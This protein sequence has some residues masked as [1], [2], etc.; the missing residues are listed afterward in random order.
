MERVSPDVRAVLEVIDEH[1]FD[2][3]FKFSSIRISKATRAAFQEQLRATPLLY[4]RVRRVEVALFLLDYTEA[5]VPEIAKLVAYPN[6][7]SFNHTFKKLMGSTP[8]EER[9]QWRSNQGEGVLALVAGHSQGTRIAGAETDRLCLVGAL[10]PR[11]AAFHL[12]M[13]AH[14]VAK[15]RDVERIVDLADAYL[16]GFEGDAEARP[17]VPVLDLPEDTSRP[18]EHDALL[19][20]AAEPSRQA[21]SR[22]GNEVPEEIQPMILQLRTNF[23][24]PDYSVDEMREILHASTVDLARFTRAM[25]ISPWQYVLEARMETA[26]R[27]LRDT[28]LSIPDIAFL[29][30]YADPPPFRRIFVRWAGQ[31]TP[32]EYR[33]RVRDVVARVGPM[34]EQLVHWRFLERVW[35]RQ[36]DEEEGVALLRYM[37][38]VYA[39]PP[40]DLGS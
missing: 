11:K 15:N 20:A 6:V 32:I 38:R 16:A 30:G 18:E 8:M 19:A 10:P 3:A 2:P 14:V 7:F 13:L 31:L 25:G 37:E 35:S 27:L 29:L 9:R 40:C 39:F 12:A 21:V 34:P 1:L 26:A 22:F 36:A 23:T 4:V 33:A 5:R 24:K 28:S 17:E